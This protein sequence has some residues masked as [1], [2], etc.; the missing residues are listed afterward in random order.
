LETLNELFPKTKEEQTIFKVDKYLKGYKRI[1]KAVAFSFAGVTFNFIVLKI[2]KLVVFGVWYDRKLLGDNWFPFDKYD[3]SGYNVAIAWQSFGSILFVGGLLGSDLTL[4]CLVSLIAM[5]FDIL[6]M[7][8]EKFQANDDKEEFNELIKEHGKLLKMSN[9]L[10][11]IFTPSIL[12]NFT[13]SSIL[14]CL[15][16]YLVSIAITADFAMKFAGLLVGA[17]LQVLSLC[18]CG[19]KLTTAAEKVEFSAYGCDWSSN[20]K[21]MKTLLVMTMQRS[22]KQTL[23]TAFKFS[24]VNYQAFTAVN[25]LRLSDSLS[26]SDSIDRLSTHLTRIS[27]C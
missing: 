26:N 20:Q 13:F 15:V 19:Q 16:G 27:R 8:L 6:A 22:Q 1:E 23:L 4:Y 5:Q 14:I 3:P 9:D 25:R 24:A 17:L 7:K 2:L 18:N 10:E 12:F 21:K 11:E